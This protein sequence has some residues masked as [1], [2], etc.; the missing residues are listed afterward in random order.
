ME[1]RIRVYIVED[2]VMLRTRLA[3]DICAVG[4]FE[5]VGT[6][7][8]AAHALAAIAELCPDIVLADIGL[9]EGTGVEIIRKVQ[10]CGCASVPRVFV[11]TNH[12][13]PQFRRHCMG[14]GAED[15]F[16]KSLEY[17]RFL[18]VMRQLSAGK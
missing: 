15:F 2:S 16:D 3:V 18:E 8:G 4:D 1:N 9:A 17:E 13:Q 10:E 14:L 5:I 12:A 11:L 7:S 6:A